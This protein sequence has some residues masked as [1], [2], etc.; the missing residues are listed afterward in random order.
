MEDGRLSVFVAVTGRGSTTGAMVGPDRFAVVCILTCAI[1][2]H[3]NKH[4]IIS[5][6]LSVLSVQW[7]QWYYQHS[8]F[9]P[10]SGS[11]NCPQK[12]C[13]CKLYFQMDAQR[14]RAQSQRTSLEKNPHTLAPGS[15]FQWWGHPAWDMAERITILE[16][17]STQLFCRWDKHMPVSSREDDFATSCHRK[18]ANFCH[19]FSSKAHLKYWIRPQ[20][21]ITLQVFC[22]VTKLE[23]RGKNN[24]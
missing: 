13:L 21:K 12:S 11:Q 16:L 14:N 5:R 10:G 19:Y 8:F 7:L 24:N 4:I 1:A 23:K 20:E 3:C 9:A 6:A 18:F 17:S 15:V 22:P 2:C